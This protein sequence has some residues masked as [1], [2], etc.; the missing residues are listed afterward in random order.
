MPDHRAGKAKEN[1]GHDRQ[2]PGV[3]AEHPGQYHI[4]DRQPQQ[5]TGGHVLHVVSLFL[6]LALI[7]DADTVFG[8]QVGQG[9]VVE[10]G[11]NLVGVALLRVQVR[12]D[13]DGQFAVDAA[14]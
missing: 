2:G 5:G 10:A 11:N 12:V 14:Q 8:F 7:A 4:N 13:G 6:Q 1:R 3:G 9:A